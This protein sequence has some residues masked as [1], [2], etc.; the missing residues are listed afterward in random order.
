MSVHQVPSS[1]PLDSKFRTAYAYTAVMLATIAALMGRWGKAILRHL[2][3][4]AD[5]ALATVQFLTSKTGAAVL[6]GS[7]FAGAVSYQVFRIVMIG[8]GAWWTI[9]LGIA[10]DTALLPFFGFAL[11]VTGAFAYKLVV[12][13]IIKVGKAAWSWVTSFHFGSR[14][15]ELAVV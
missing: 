1:K 4:A 5:A 15:P 7:A 14:K 6:L 2:I 11:G 9:P 12:S 10:I 8:V 3:D 13:P